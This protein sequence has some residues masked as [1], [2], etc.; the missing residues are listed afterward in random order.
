METSN[1]R[2]KEEII[3]TVRVTEKSQVR[4]CVEKGKEKVARWSNNSKAGRKQQKVSRN[5]VRR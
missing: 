3:T 4:G 1:F 5:D 2:G